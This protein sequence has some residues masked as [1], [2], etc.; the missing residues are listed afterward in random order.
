MLETRILSTDDP[1]AI[2]M[3]VQII[4][5]QG[6][7]AFPTDTLYGVAASPFN[8]SAI[9]KVFLAKQRPRNKALPILIGDLNQLETL[10]S[11]ISDRV[12][13]IA[14]TFWP[15]ALTLILPKHPSLPTELSSFPTV[16]IR[17]PNL[18]FTLKLLRQTGPLA[19]TSANISG[20]ID[21]TTAA[22]VLTQLGGRVDLILDG[23]TTPGGVASTI[24]AVT[25]EEMKILR[26]GPVALSDIEAL[27]EEI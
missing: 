4:E 26:R 5:N 22:E 2:P 18:D 24:L 14:E 8:P 9:E 17:M 1:Q 15:G 11:F 3:A 21:P 10:V 7:V 23:G 13:I 20:G 27:F 12:K 19:T 16:G 6:L 25:N